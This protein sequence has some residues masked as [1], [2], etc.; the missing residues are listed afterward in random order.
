MNYPRYLK[1]F[2]KITL[3]LS[4]TTSLVVSAIQESFLIGSFML[5]YV[6]VLAILLW[7]AVAIF[8]ELGKWVCKDFRKEQ[9]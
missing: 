3:I 7:F 8:I 1:G 5:I 6:P 4:I 2:S 9:I